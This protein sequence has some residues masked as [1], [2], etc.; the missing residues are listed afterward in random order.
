MPRE[1]LQAL[2]FLSRLPKKEAAQLEKEH[3]KLA[4]ILDGIRG[5]S[6]LPAAIF[7]I[8]PKKEHIAVHEANRLGIPVIAMVDTNCDPDMIQFPIPSNDDAIR[9]IRLITAGIADAVLDG[10]LESQVQKGHEPVSHEVS[11]EVREEGDKEK[12]GEEV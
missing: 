6:H 12:S 1:A 3:G 5:L 10:A 4:S 9:S 11:S 8:D 7:V 2:D